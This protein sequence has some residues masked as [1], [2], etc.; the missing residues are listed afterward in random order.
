MGEVKNN[1]LELF[2]NKRV[3]VVQKDNFIKDGVLLGYDDRFI[4]LE[5]EDEKRLYRPKGEG[6]GKSRV[7]ISLDFIAS[8]QEL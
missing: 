1:F 6:S 8:I 7:L 2:K 4:L 5:F 3:K